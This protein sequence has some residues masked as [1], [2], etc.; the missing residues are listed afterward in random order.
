MK[1]ELYFV[2][3]GALSTLTG[4]YAY[5]R[6]L[7]VVLE[8]AGIKVHPVALSPRFPAPDQAALADAGAQLAGIPDNALVLA[9]G[10][11]YGV[12]DAIA[13]AEHKRL[14]IIALCH[15]P[16]ALE[17]GLDAEAAARLFTSEKNA[18]RL[19]CAVVVTSQATAA[20]L[21]SRFDIAA[22][23]ITVALPG[24]HKQVFAP[25]RGNPPRLLT[26]ATLTRRKAHDVLIAALARIH[27][28]D[29]TA[30]FV[31]GDHFD[32]VWA[33]GLKE[34][35]ANLNLGERICFAGSLDDLSAE[36]AAA[37]MFVLP[38]RFEGYGMVFAEALAFGLPIV[39]AQAGAVPD[40]VPASAGVLVPPDDVD[41]LAA[42]LQGILSRPAQFKALQ[43]GARTAAAGLPGW[44]DTGDK[45]IQLLQ[46]VATNTQYKNHEAYP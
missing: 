33:S 27:T 42:A 22:D 10:L 38:S 20:L 36:Y 39:A 37:D 15:H 7:I 5:D 8:A 35:C 11:A 6:E 12:M 40:V 26:V 2:F 24:T 29:W 43:Q 3:P 4:G 1:P 30:R 28:L 9:D 16:L 46:T 13:E 19:A 14:N 21:Q 44:Q 25:C 41:A 45:V 23:K 18:L 32:L 34:Q 31:G 17:S